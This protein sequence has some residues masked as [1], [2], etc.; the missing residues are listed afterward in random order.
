MTPAEAI[1]AIAAG[2]AKRLM[3]DWLEPC[4]EVGNEERIYVLAAASLGCEGYDAPEFD[5]LDLLM[6]TCKK[7]PCTFLKDDRCEIHATEYKPKQCRESLGCEKSGPDNYEMARLWNTGAG[8]EALAR[9]K[10]P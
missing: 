9:W 8:R 2:N 7:G 5:L 1:K 6:G 3:R 4:S 10:K